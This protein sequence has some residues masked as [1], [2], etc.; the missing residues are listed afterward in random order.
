MIMGGYEEGN[1]NSGHGY[2]YKRPD[3]ILVRCGGPAM[4]SVCAGD[5]TR[6]ANLAETR[7]PDPDVNIG[8]VDFLSRKA[9]MS[10]SEMRKMAAMLNTAADLKE[11]ADARITLPPKS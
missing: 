4:C 2:V 1:P 3:G 6:E 8:L 9:R 5:A 10:A 11:R 7:N